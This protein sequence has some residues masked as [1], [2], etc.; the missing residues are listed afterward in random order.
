MPENL[1]VE[2]QQ[3]AIQLPSRICVV[4]R[5]RQYPASSNVSHPL[6]ADSAWCWGRKE[7]RQRSLSILAPAA[8]RLAWYKN[9]AS[10]VLKSFRHN[11]KKTRRGSYSQAMAG[12]LQA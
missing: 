2:L 5:G 6:T 11:A 7:K 3:S 12:N 9:A 10:T 8:P 1:A 4:A